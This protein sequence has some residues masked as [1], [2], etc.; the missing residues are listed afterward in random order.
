MGNARLQFEESSLARPAGELLA[1]IGAQRRREDD[2]ALDPGRGSCRPVRGEVR[3]PRGGRVG[4]AGGAVPAADGRGEPAAVRAAGGHED[5]RAR[6]RRCWSRPGWRS[7]GET[8]ARLSAAT[9]SGSTSRSGCSRGRRCCCWMSRSSGS[10]PPTGAALELVAHLA[11]GGTT[12]IFSTHD[13]QEAER[14]GG[15]CWCSPTA[16]P[17]RRLGR[18]AARGRAARG[19]GGRRPRLRD[20]LRRLPPPPGALTCA[21]CC[22]RTCRSC[23]A[24]R[25]RRS[26]SSPTRS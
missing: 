20:R 5:S 18:G 1:V 23:A 2:P 19:A 21:G 6:P 17:L 11:G 7:A 9:S 15:G 16:S 12:V 26:C 3:L 14:Y 8:V 25:C 22:S 4:S 13:I 10:T 24:R